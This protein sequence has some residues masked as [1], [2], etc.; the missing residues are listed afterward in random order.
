MQNTDA[1][2]ENERPNEKDALDL[3]LDAALRQYAAVEP[4]AG[5]EQRVLAQ[6]QS[7]SARLRNRSWL[8]WCAAGAIAA[9]LA[10]TLA[11]AWRSNRPPRISQRNPSAPIEGLQ[12]SAT[13]VAVNGDIRV[14]P[15][16]R[17]RQKTTPQHVPQRP[18]VADLPKLDQFPSPRPLSEQ[19]KLALEYVERFPRQASLIAQAQNNFAQQQ[20]ME[21]RQWQRNS[22]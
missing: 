1:A 9:L 15:V 5:L 14:T 10:L 6:L 8:Q 22:Q 3:A 12:P 2:R 13:R 17:V 7:E 11:L 21:E 4:R 20:E 19:E 16:I 18:V